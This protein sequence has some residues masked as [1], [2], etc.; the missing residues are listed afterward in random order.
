MKF[1]EIASVCARVLNPSEIVGLDRYVCANDRLGLRLRTVDI[2]CSRR[3]CDLE[4]HHLQIDFSASRIR[5]RRNLTK[6]RP[7]RLALGV[8]SY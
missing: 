5:N 4:A 1:V 7:Y 8:V 6:K 3:D 2:T